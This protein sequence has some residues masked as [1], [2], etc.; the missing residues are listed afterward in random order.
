MIYKNG[1]RSKIIIKDS[2]IESQLQQSTGAQTLENVLNK[3]D[4]RIEKIESNVKWLYAYGGVGG[5][6]GGGGSDP[7]AWNYY[8]LIQPDGAD[9]PVQISDNNT[10]GTEPAA[11]SKGPA[12]LTLGVRNPTEGVSYTVT[13]RYEGISYGSPIVLSPSNAWRAVVTLNL[14]KNSSI[15]IE[16]VNQSTFSPLSMTYNYVVDPFVISQ[17]SFK[18]ANPDDTYVYDIS[19]PNIYLEDVENHG[20]MAFC[21][22]TCNLSGYYEYEWD[23]DGN[24]TS[25]NGNVDINDIGKIEMDFTEYLTSS[26]STA[27]S[28][29]LTVKYRQKGQITFVEFPTQI[30][31]INVIPSVLTLAIYPT[32]GLYDEIS[33]SNIPSESL[34]KNNNSPFS[35][36]FT[37]FYGINRGRRCQLKIKTEQVG[38]MSDNETFG[39]YRITSREFWGLK[40]SSSQAIIQETIPTGTKV[41]GFNELNELKYYTLTGSSLSFSAVTSWQESNYVVDN[42]DTTIDFT[43]GSYPSTSII[44]VRK[45]S[46]W[47]MMVC[48]YTMAGE[49][50]ITTKFFYDNVVATDFNWW[51]EKQNA[52]VK[53]AISRRIGDNEVSLTA[54]TS[55]SDEIVVYNNPNAGQ[56]FNDGRTYVLNVGLQYNETSDDK[57][58]IIRLDTNET[59]NYL[60][61]YQNKIVVNSG[62]E[63]IVNIFIDKTES[64]KFDISNLN[65]FHLLTIAHKLVMV[66]GV[67]NIYE[68][69][70]YIDGTIIGAAT[71][72]PT[73]FNIYQKLTLK[74]SNYIINS[75]ELDY[76]NQSINNDTNY[77]DDFVVYYFYTWKIKTYNS[78]SVV[79]KNS[80]LLCQ[81]SVSITPPND[82]EPPKNYKPQKK[83]GLVQITN[84]YL[85]NLMHHSDNIP[86]LVVELDKYFTIESQPSGSTVFEWMNNSYSES[87][88]N[89]AKTHQYNINELYWI[90]K[91]RE[92]WQTECKFKKSSRIFTNVDGETLAN[93]RFYLQIQGSSTTNNKDKNFTLG[94]YQP[95]E[96]SKK[97]LFS[98]T[99]FY[100]P[101]VSKMPSSTF[102]PEQSFTLK[103]DHVDSS[104][105]NN[106]CMGDFV[107]RHTSDSVSRSLNP[108]NRDWFTNMVGTNVDVNQSKY[109]KRCLTGFPFYMILKVVDNKEENSESEFY[110]LGIYN[111]NLGR[112]SEYNL[113]YRNLKSNLSIGSVSEENDVYYN[114]LHGSTSLQENGFT[115]VSSTADNIMNSGFIT[116]EIQGNTGLWDF[117][118]YSNSILF[119]PTPLHMFDD[120]VHTDN[121]SNFQNVISK[122][123]QRVSLAG[124]YLFQSI[125]KKNMADINP[126]QDGLTSENYYN[127]PGTV[128]DYHC[129]YKYADDKFVFSART[130]IDAQST[131][132]QN[133]LFDNNDVEPV[134]QRWLEYD[135][136]N[137]YYTTC[138][139]FCMMDSVQK[140]LCIK[141]WNA[142]EN[143]D[144]MFG[145]FFYDMDTCLGITNQ[146]SDADFFS[147][148]DFYK[149]KTIESGTTIV[150][151]EEMTKN[152]VQETYLFR[153]FFPKS[154]Y[155]EYDI[156]TEDYA[157]IHGFDI[158]SSYLFAIAKYAF[159]TLEGDDK[160]KLS[161]PCN[162]WATW[163]KS[164]GPLRTADYFVDEYF[165]GY[166]KNTSEIYW[167]LN[168]REKYLNVYGDSNDWEDDYPELSKNNLKFFYS[169]LL[170][171]RRIGYVR[172]WLSKRIDIM[173]IYM[174]IE[175][176]QQKTLSDTTTIA[177]GKTVTNYEPYRNY[178]TDIDNKENVSIFNCITNTGSGDEAALPRKSDV[179]IMLLTS[180]YSPLLI[181]RGGSYFPYILSD[182]KKLY[183]IKVGYTGDELSLFGGSRKW[184]YVHTFNSLLSSLTN[185]RIFSVISKN[186]DKIVISDDDNNKLSYNNEYNFNVP[187]VKTISMTSNRANTQLGGTLRIDNIE[188]SK[189]GCYLSLKEIDIHGSKISLIIDGSG[190]NISK[191]NV[192]NLKGANLLEISNINLETELV[193]S[194]AMADKMVFRTW[195]EDG[196]IYLGNVTSNP[197]YINIIP[198]ELIVTCKA[199]QTNANLYIDNI[200]TIEQLTFSGFKNVSV[201]NCPKLRTVTCDDVRYDGQGSTHVLH[202]FTLNDSSITS[203][204]LNDC[205]NLETLNV[206]NNTGLSSLKLLKSPTT[207]KITALNI[208]NTKI[209]HISW[210][211][212]GTD[213]DQYIIDLRECNIDVQFRCQSNREVKR[214]RCYNE[215]EHPMNGLIS[216][217]GC[218]ALE[219]VYGFFCLKSSMFQNASKFSLHGSNINEVQWKGYSVLANNGRVMIPNE[220]LRHSGDAIPTI[221]DIYQSG[222]NVTNALIDE[223]ATSLASVFYGTN[224]TI[225]DVYYTLWLM[226]LA[227]NCTSL[228]TM[229]YG[230]SIDYGFTSQTNN[231]PNIYMFCGCSHVKTMRL[232]FSSLGKGIV[233]LMDEIMKPLENLEDATHIFHG[234]TFA[235][236]QNLFQFNNKLKNV[237]RFSPKYLIGDYSGGELTYESLSSMTAIANAV[238][239]DNFGRFSK[240]LY[241]CHDVT[242]MDYFLRS[243]EYLNYTRT[244]DN[245]KLVPSGVTTLRQS[246]VSNYSDGDFPLELS[247]LFENPSAMTIMSSSFMSI[248]NPSTNLKQ[249]MN[250]IGISLDGVNITL[251][252][253]FLNGFNNLTNLS[254]DSEEIDSGIDKD[255]TI[256][257]GN[258]YK[259]TF[260]GASVNKFINVYNNNIEFPYKIFTSTPKLTYLTGFFAGSKPNATYNNQIALP[261]NLFK[262]TPLLKKLDFMFTNVEFDY[263]LSESNEFNSN[264]STCSGLTSVRYMFGN[265]VPINYASNPT[266]PAT[267]LS[268]YEYNNIYPDYIHLKS[269]IPYKFFNHGLITG[270][271]TYEGTN[272]EPTLDEN[273]NPVYTDIGTAT[274]TYQEQ[275]NANGISDMEGCFM[276]A[277]IYS[278]EAPVITNEMVNTIEFNNKDYIPFKYYKKNNTWCQRQNNG[279]EDVEKTV[280]WIYDGHYLE[281]IYSSITTSV[282]EL[283][284]NLEDFIK[285]TGQSQ[286]GYYARATQTVQNTELKETFLFCTPPDLFRYCNSNCN[287]NYLFYHSGCYMSSYYQRTIDMTYGLF[288]RLCPW[289]LNP[290]SQTTSTTGMFSNCKRLVA[291]KETNE[292]DFYIIPS[293]FFK[294]TPNITNLSYMFEGICLPNNTLVNSNIMNGIS[295]RNSLNVSYMFFRVR[296]GDWDSSW[297]GNTYTKFSGVFNNYQISNCKACFAQL[298]SAT[299]TTSLPT[300]PQGFA[301]FSDGNFSE[302]YA[303]T[304]YNNNFNYSYVYHGFSCS[305]TDNNN[306][307]KEK[308]TVG[309]FDFRDLP[310]NTITNNYWPKDGTV[311]IYG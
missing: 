225:F 235:C 118:Q 264:F 174:N 274:V 117:S 86:V 254:Y 256:Y 180:Q 188:N 266:S 241:N 56:E 206:S 308:T 62:V 124:G 286:G 304:V 276:C 182:D 160:E 105:T 154:D 77:I 252:D 221:D 74:P 73:S 184:N 132:L 27:H 269:K 275:F 152:L 290:L 292:T 161:N 273:N 82:S 214:I 171:G 112:D 193:L 168:Y 4:K 277:D 23:I 167:N 291:Y 190:L 141:T 222:D 310:S 123:V 217:S 63:N 267:F 211:D 251:T 240:I 196:S 87:S 60:E 49:S 203:L 17:V 260:C 142:Q 31:S 21:N 103:A 229:W 199:G 135:S 185:G 144:A 81:Y 143:N 237:S 130:S 6:S 36:S 14:T 7:T 101:N 295:T 175:N 245:E 30:F 265:G 9:T 76:I 113:G 181:R 8:V 210:T 72:L 96:P 48:Y 26:T 300:A 207:H 296:H 127:I 195:S 248:Q 119:K 301:Q 236:S 29:M 176:Q 59:S 43:E 37:L 134:H 121:L 122:F 68:I 204:T 13:I 151:G 219:R 198:K 257:T 24:K 83:N 223:S 169:S 16:Y 25:G 261:G 215:K 208:S 155:P 163:R 255:Y 11:L 84:N 100:D 70:A 94:L 90:T 227:P 279:I 270:Q 202:S 230:S 114:L 51:P 283:N 249:A 164:D 125:L 197:N 294:N 41:A 305:Q 159:S 289:L 156:S 91:Y 192:S 54:M 311:I 18:A 33:P 69:I 126:S 139:A 95:N 166:M 258:T 247:D 35:L 98:P 34:M 108:N 278:Y 224:P 133:I 233:H 297:S 153:D 244:S 281:N 271:T 52:Y 194:N 102:L 234:L 97:H 303:T 231:N 138:M 293:T 50:D 71:N 148:S 178:V 165:A 158:P 149:T 209:A 3:Q 272:T 228:S 39:I 268:T 46:G 307:F 92:D 79:S 85:E 75:L 110:F 136:L 28:I 298:V 186:I 5:R 93:F 140:N 179:D 302:R 309:G 88:T 201:K 22:Y 177:S 250:A 12:Q 116:A 47:Y 226:R 137:A 104:H 262:D 173:D 89:P 189:K 306:M 238:T 55:T 45:G 157:D 213:L 220:I 172:N 191:V 212:A 246:F 145:V 53:K 243:C 287:V 15:Y 259:S 19:N 120:I 150:N 183:E 205:E 20:F 107:N 80:Q 99:F 38:Y 288:G 216:F 67:N 106:V 57:T 129:Q 2:E 242:N 10:P 232:M 40:E 187:R 263:E 111:F 131:D 170:K 253:S 58:P 146:G 218:A 284:D 280:R 64:D 1:D 128:P 282:H 239:S 61:I 65:G 42:Y 285:I 299:T 147:F 115:F 66:D 162:Y 200:Q 109:L 32:D 44:P 78:Q